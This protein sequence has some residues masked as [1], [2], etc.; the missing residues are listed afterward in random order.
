MSEV[1]PA[2]LLAPGSI[3]LAESAA[4]KIEAILACGRALVE[5][6]CVT[7]AYPPAMLE[8]EQSITTYIGEGVAIP[9]ATLAGKEAVLRDGLC[10]LRFPDGV[11]WGG[12]TVVLCIG[13][14]A[15]G[16]GHVDILAQLAQVLM[17]PEKAEALRQATDPDT[18]LRMLSPSS[19]TEGE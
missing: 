6:G 16:E 15:K 1:R 11:D 18:V 17:V 4:N 5:A 8:R 10:F 9:H 7:E 14:A 2:D 12:N 19:D 13:I 3:R